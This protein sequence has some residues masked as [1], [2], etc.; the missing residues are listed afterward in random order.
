MTDPLHLLIAYDGS[1]AAKEAIAVA[2]KLYGPHARATV[3]YAWEPLVMYAG[4]MGMAAPSFPT[5]GSEREEQDAV[6]LVE[7]G[8]RHAAAL[9]LEAEA[10][11]VQ[12]VA[13]PWRTIVDTAERDAA[14]L[15]VI[16]TRGLSGVRSL[17]M[18]SCSHHV[19]QH[20]VC[21]V[22]V[23]PD[24]EIRDARRAAAQAAADRSNGALPGR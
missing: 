1:D 19:A 7:D 18:G 5:G 11:A 10:R 20:A 24:G 17:L 9:G 14:D 3:L 21:P 8:A 2:A 22:L 4:G 16:G 15:V 12:T 23:V 13:A 6:S